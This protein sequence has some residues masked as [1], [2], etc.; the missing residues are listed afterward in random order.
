MRSIV[1][2]IT[3]ASL[4][5]CSA[6]RA[7]EGGVNLPS[8]GTGDTD[9]SAVPSRVVKSPEVAEVQQR[10][11]VLGYAIGPVDGRLGPK[12]Q[13][14]INAYLTER[15]LPATG[16]ISPGLITEVEGAVKAPPMPPQSA[17]SPSHVLNQSQRDIDPAKVEI[18][19]RRLTE[20]GFYRGAMDGVVGSR[21]SDAIKAYQQS[22]GM[23]ATGWIFPDLVAELAA[24]A[25]EESK[26]EVEPLPPLPIKTWV[27]KDLVG[28]TLHALPGD[29]LGTV[30][31]VVVGGDGMVAGVLADISNRYG[32]D[33]S[34]TLILWNDVAS[35]VGRPVVILPLSA[36][37]AR[38][39]RRAP[40]PFH[41]GTDQMLGSQ[42]IGA[43]AKI[44]GEN[45]G[46]VDEAVF[47]QSGKLTQIKVHG[48]DDSGSRDVP[49][50]N[51]TLMPAEEAVEIGEVPVVRRFESDA[52]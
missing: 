34:E 19:Q 33:K 30:V 41:L 39:L 2:L 9:R 44:R 12:T 47:E 22:K 46:E 14:G 4:L 6:A 38:S 26:A 48:D 16:W 5:V 29:L 52:S 3:A 21:L 1:G 37:R 23:P 27:P 36:D 10:L 13:A 40:P 7:F 51:V 50:A 31:E 43:R 17:F 32:S 18:V 20:L 45:W 42:L 35:S 49:A 25:K 28:K 24:P 11:K 15:G 8:P